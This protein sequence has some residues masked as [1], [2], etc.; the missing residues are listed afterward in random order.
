VLYLLLLFGYD[1]LPPLPDLSKIS[2]P[3]PV[4]WIQPAERGLLINGYAGQFYGGDLDLDLNTLRARGQFTRNNE[5]D[6][7]DI[8]SAQVTA[9]VTLPR[10]WLKPNLNA[11]LLRRRDD[12]TQ[13][14]PGLGFAIFT[15][16]VVAAGMFDYS[17]W[18]INN[19]TSSEATGE[20]SFIFDRITYFP[21][22]IVRGIYTGRKLKPSLFAQLHISGFH[23]EFGSPIRTGFPSPILNITYSDLWIE[24]TAGVQ[25]GVKHNTLGEYF[26]PELPIRYRIDIPAETIRVVVD[27]GI[28]LN[29][30]NQSFTVGGTYKEWLYRL[31]I[32]EDY[33][34][35]PTRDIKE[36]NLKMCARNNLCFGRIDV[37]NALHVQYNTND[38]AITFLPD[39]GII[40]TFE[41]GVG[42]L[43]LSADFRYL[44]QRS[45]T[46]KSLPRHYIINT[47]AG[48]RLHFL[49]LYFT[50]HNITD[51]KSQVYDDYF[52]TGRQYA[53]G[54]EIKHPL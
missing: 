29:I 33:E 52:Y 7:T 35:S 3:E 34:I 16:P 28:T 23:L 51:E 46:G 25:T 22:M 44:S 38:S 40:D 49:K 12:Y 30:R 9:A 47:K 27:L 53:G 4:L 17:H 45:G 10:L 15:S 43:E 2:L 6:S 18:I 20:I 19:E 13:I 14:T 11:Q 42:S 54:L 41:L 1:S 21:S 31:N 48:L 26:K 24:A 32:G 50:V 36:T 8:G 37:R 39:I 5:W